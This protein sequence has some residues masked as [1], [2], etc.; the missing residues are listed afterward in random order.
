MTLFPI[1]YTL[2]NSF[3]NLY[4]LKPADMSYIGVQNY[5]DGLSDPL[6]R[7]SLWNTFV[8]MFFTTLTESSLG[9]LLAA[10]VHSLG[11]K[12]DFL[13][14]LIIL[15]NL[16][17]PVTIILIW[18]N[19]LGYHGLIN[20]LFTLL[21]FEPVNWFMHKATAMGS[22]IFI[23]IWQ[24]T[25]FAFLLFFAALTSVPKNQYEAAKIDGAGPFANFINVTVPHIQSTLFMV[26]TLRLIDT[27]RL[28]DK[29]NILTKGGPANATTTVTQFIYQKGIGNLKIGYASAISICMTL[30]VIFIGMPA[31]IKNFR[32]E[33]PK[34]V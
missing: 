34:G 3:Y 4:L 30:I 16:I 7:L 26:V 23:D 14:F 20:K 8:F 25:P 13:R 33:K 28:F 21:G 12:T 22:L 31:L 11:K 17:P 5:I 19:L 2:Y 32:R 6:F 1:G 18:Q 29:V 9:L 24:W 15:P 10:I 27:V